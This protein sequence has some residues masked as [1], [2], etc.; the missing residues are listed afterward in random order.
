[1]SVPVFRF[2][3]SPNGRLHLGHARSALL[4]ADFAA[5]FSGRLLLRIEDIDLARCR[6][7][8]VAGILEDLTWLGLRWEEPVRRQSEHFDL[9]RA[10]AAT[11]KAEGLLYPCFCSRKAL[12][13]AVARREEETCAPWPRDPDGAPAYPGT[14]KGLDAAEAERRIA[15]GEPHALRID[16]E[17]ALKRAGG[18]LFYERFDRD[19]NAERVEAQP[20]RWGDAVIVRKDIPTSYHLSVVVDDALQEVSHVVRGKDLEA[21]TDLHVLLQRL[22]GLPTPLYHHHDLILDPMGDKLAKSRGSGALA[23]LRAR[24]VS[25]EAVRLL[26][27]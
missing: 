2:A 15:A 9:Y 10:A 18:A 1:M 13:E 26:V 8:Y 7:A 20:A 11:L 3:P 23:D 14:C 22:L 25:A 4:N 24:G 6:P 16:M 5:R 19:G 27:L 17:A 12:A 21:A